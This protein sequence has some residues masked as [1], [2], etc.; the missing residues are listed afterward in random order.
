MRRGQAA[1]VPARRNRSRVRG[2]ASL[3]DQPL[4]LRANQCGTT[5]ASQAVMNGAEDIEENV[6]LH[7]GLDRVQA[8]RVTA[9]VVDALGELLTT[10][11]AHALASG[12]SPGLSRLLLVGVGRDPHG[13]VESLVEGV[14]W[15][16]NVPDSIALEHVTA[17]LSA[18]AARLPA[19]AQAR[20]R[21][22]LPRDV[23]ALLSPGSAPG[24][25]VRFQRSRR[26]PPRPT[27]ATGK[28]GSAH[29]VSEAR[30][31]RPRAHSVADPNPHGADKLSSAHGTTQELTGDTIAEGAP[32]PHRPL[33]EG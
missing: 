21:A 30:A 4:A 22:D 1:D 26:H 3:A 23:A 33:S 14:A 20:L 6:A 2:G 8:G 9:A 28:P 32:G 19:D 31:D 7:T 17:V 16:E 11:E 24:E 13:D 12:L 27:L 15:R 5:F 18:I 10:D 25:P 29:P